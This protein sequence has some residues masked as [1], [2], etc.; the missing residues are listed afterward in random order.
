MD[1]ED[2]TPQLRRQRPGEEAMYAISLVRP[3]RTAIKVLAAGLITSALTLAATAP[4]AHADLI[5]YI[6]WSSYLPGW[7]DQYV[8]TSDNDCVAGRP[9]CLD[10]TLKEQSR[11][12]DQTAASCS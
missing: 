12:A 6:P 4:P 2:Q 5:P 7:T 3:V 1:K 11:I 9:N 8:P 10:G